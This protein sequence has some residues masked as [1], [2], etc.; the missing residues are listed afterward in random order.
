MSVSFR[1][2]GCS[3]FLEFDHPRDCSRE[4]TPILR[5]RLKVSSAEARERI[6]FR[7]TIVRRRL[8]LGGDPALL[9]QLVQGGIKRAVADL[10]NI[11]GNLLEPKADSE[12]VER[13]QREDLQKQQVQGALNQVRRFAHVLPSVTEAEYTYSAR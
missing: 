8:P 12:A 13:L 11:A 10:Q 7:A 2:L 9:L 4:P 3:G 6:E 1:A 5:F